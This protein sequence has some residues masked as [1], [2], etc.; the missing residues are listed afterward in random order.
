MGAFS[1]SITA[2]V[3]GDGSISR[4]GGT[5]FGNNMPRLVRM[6][7]YRLEAYLDGHLLLF[8][9]EDVPG[10]IGAVGT[11]LGTHKIN[12]A[13]MAVGREKSSPGGPAIGVLNLDSPPLQD[14]LDEVLHVE[15]VQ[16]VKHIVM[17]A[18]GE[19][20]PWLQ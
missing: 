15:G 10:I 16:R 2:E 13:Q 19:L 6:D 4:A 11:I 9:H 5:L 14:A 3:I 17:P 12:I 20:P 1:S 7:N 8:S 18:R